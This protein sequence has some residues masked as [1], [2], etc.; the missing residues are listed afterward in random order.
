MQEPE[1]TALA[2]PEAAA[3]GAEDSSYVDS[4]ANEN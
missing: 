1:P 2:D 3:Q 4:E